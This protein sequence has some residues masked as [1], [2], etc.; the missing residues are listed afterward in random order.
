MGKD[1]QIQIDRRR[2]GGGTEREKREE[3]QTDRHTHTP[4]VGDV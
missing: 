2:D 4:K 1:R 3:R